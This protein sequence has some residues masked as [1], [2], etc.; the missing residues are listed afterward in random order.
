M[1][2]QEGMFFVRKKKKRRR[3]LGSYCNI[4]LIMIFFIGV[5]CK[6]YDLY[7]I[8][9][10]L[11]S[12]IQDYERLIASEQTK[13]ASL[14]KEKEYIESDFYIEMIAREKLGLVKP[15]EIVFMERA[16]E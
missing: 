6:T 1:Y 5:G 2:I 7:Q 8:R 14:L 12:Q 9:Q 4:L 11:Q 10:G 3:S 15:D 13:T 16:Q